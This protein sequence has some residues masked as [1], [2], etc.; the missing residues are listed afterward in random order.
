MYSIYEIT[1]VIIAFVVLFIYIKT[2]SH[3][4]ECDAEEDF[5]NFTSSASSSPV[6]AY[7]NS[8]SNSTNDVNIKKI[9]FI[10]KV[11]S[12]NVF[13]KD[14]DYSKISKMTTSEL[15]M[16]VKNNNLLYFVDLLN[17]FTKDGCSQS[18]LKFILNLFGNKYIKFNNMSNIM[19][20]DPNVVLS[21]HLT[22]YIQVKNILKSYI[23]LLSI[24]KIDITTF[25][26]SSSEIDST[27]TNIIQQL[28]Q[29]NNVLDKIKTSN[30]NLYTQSDIVNNNLINTYKTLV[31]DTIKFT[32]ITSSNSRALNQIKSY[33]Q[34]K[35]F[36][37]S[38]IQFW[39]PFYVQFNLSDT[40][41]TKANT[42]DSIDEVFTKIIFPKIFNYSLTL[43]DLMNQL[44]NNQDRQLIIDAIDFFNK[45]VSSYLV[46]FM[47]VITEQSDPSL[48]LQL[49]KLESQVSSLYDLIMQT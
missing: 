42:I 23:D 33:N 20:E 30:T 46:I 13:Y 18:D 17:Q 15:G 16:Y 1:L 36:N 2:T 44:K 8:K 48:L 38:N 19:Q 14:S 40:D 29:I 4:N 24:N 6:I 7:I 3:T 22:L 37:N 25:N 39:I 28:P 43:I 9:L 45:Y 34:T 47:N 12:N 10:P 5:G 21:N 31:C 26:K 49:Q 41:I 27:L 32:S 11:F 35:K